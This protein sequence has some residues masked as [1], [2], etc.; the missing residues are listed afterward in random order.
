MTRSKV[1]EHGILNLR[2][3]KLTARNNF[4]VL[5]LDCSDS[6]NWDHEILRVAG[7]LV[8][9]S[10]NQA[11]RI[12][13]KLPSLEALAIGLRELTN[14]YHTFN[15]EAA[16]KYCE[17]INDLNK[18]TGVVGRLNRVVPLDCEEVWIWERHDGQP[19]HYEYPRIRT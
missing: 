14:S 15:L 12:R 7:I 18:K 5:F 17:D 8:R 19:F 13:A 11:R 4:E 16:Y 6:T 9:A 2:A 10:S 3:N 1:M